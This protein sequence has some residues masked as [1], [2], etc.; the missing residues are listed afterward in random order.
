MALQFYEK[1]GKM[2]ISQS[3]KNGEHQ[4]TI[5]IWSGNCLAV[6]T[7][8]YKDPHTGDEMIGLYSF[9]GNEQHI[10]N[11]T[12]EFNGNVFADKILSVELNL[13]YKQNYTLLKYFVKQMSPDLKVMCYYKEPEKQ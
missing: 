10:K 2:T 3:R 6:F 1:M 9:F 12:K 8:D 5:D 11:M 4:Y 7:Y 13:Y